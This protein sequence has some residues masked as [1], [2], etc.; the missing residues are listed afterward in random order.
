MPSGVVQRSQSLAI[1]QGNRPIKA[2]IPGHDTNSANRKK[3]PKIEEEF[4][5]PRRHCDLMPRRPSRF[6]VRCVHKPRWA[7]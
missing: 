2:L 1:W 3:D 7:H 4:S 5:F 6:V